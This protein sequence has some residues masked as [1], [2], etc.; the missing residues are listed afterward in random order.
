MSRMKREFSCDQYYKSNGGKI[1][2]AAIHFGTTYSGYAFSFS[3]DSKN[4]P[5]NIRMSCFTGPTHSCSIKAPTAVLFDARKRFHS[6]GYEAEDKYYELAAE[7]EHRDWYFFRN[8][9]MKFCIEKAGIADENLTIV[10]ESEAASIYCQAIDLERDRRFATIHAGTKYMV[11]DLEG[12]TV[13]I[14]VHE[15][16]SNDGLKE[17]F[18]AS[19]GSWFSTKVDEEFY[20]LIISVVGEEVFRK[21]C[22]E[23]TEYYLDLQRELEIKK[24]I[25]KSTGT[26]SLKVP[27]CF[28]DIYKKEKG[29][30]IQTAV[31]ESK[32][33]GKIAWLRD[34]IRM[35]NDVWN[36]FF[37]PC[38]DNIV[39]HISYLLDGM[40]VKGTSV[41][42]MVGGIS[43]CEI[44]QN[45]VKNAFPSVKIIIPERAEEAVLKGSVIFGHRPLA[46]TSCVSKY[47]YGICTSPLFDSSI[48]PEFR[49]VTING[50]DRC[51]D[52]FKTYIYA[53]ENVRVGDAR[54]GKHST[55][56]PRQKEMKLKMYVSTRPN[57]MYVD[58][59]DTEYIGDVVVHLPESDELSVV[60]VKMIFGETELM[61]VATELS[62]HIRYS[63]FFDFL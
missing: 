59:N 28:H 1:L 24:Q 9:K 57:P 38:C 63:A 41:F 46:I 52:V 61:V 16:Q 19:G 34:K 7:N 2:V 30:D 27:A 45:A 39:R 53:G 33:D 54:S 20:Q 32:Y 35:D 8:F 29:K 26:I 49:R 62:Q 23:Y 14:T 37:K 36:G 22:N 11:I 4:H 51:R 3:Y 17:L 60:Y 42:L 31:R 47:T 58:E 25:Q 43:N 50:K 40:A 12:S 48:H 5:L 18:K 56:W 15:K 6:F 21:F 44:I 13:D 55:L 10:L